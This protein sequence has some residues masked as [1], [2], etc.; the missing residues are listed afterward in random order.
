MI[1]IDTEILLPI[2]GGQNLF[3]MVDCIRT[4]A[5]TACLMSVCASLKRIKEPFSYVT[6]RSSSNKYNVGIRWCKNH[7]H[8][9]WFMVKYRLQMAHPTEALSIW[10][11]KE[12]CD[13]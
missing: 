12:E 6:N 5:I 7:I 8:R 3:V 2:D 9:W 10:Y 1:F 4:T 11:K 13:G